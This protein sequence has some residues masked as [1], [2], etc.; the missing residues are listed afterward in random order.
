ML[1]VIDKDS[2]RTQSPLVEHWV[3]NLEHCDGYRGGQAQEMPEL[4]VFMTDKL[5]LSYRVI[6]SC[7][8]LFQGGNCRP[9][10]ASNR[11]QSNAE[12]S[13]R[14]AGVGNSSLNAGSMV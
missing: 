13:G 8:V 12:K 5:Q 3:F 14:T 9:N 2:S 11:E 4:F 10:V 6:A 7:K 1:V